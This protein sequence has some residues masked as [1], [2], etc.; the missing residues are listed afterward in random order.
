MPMDATNISDSSYAETGLRMRAMLMEWVR[1]FCLMYRHKAV[2]VFEKSLLW[3]P[4][5]FRRLSNAVKKCSN[6][7]KIIVVRLY[8]VITAYKSTVVA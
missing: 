8:N 3:R 7:D 4:N 6:V 2:S 5:Y 1:K